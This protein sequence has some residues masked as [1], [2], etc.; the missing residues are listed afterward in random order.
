MLSNKNS[1]SRAWRIAVGKP[2]VI[3]V[4]LGKIF[5]EGQEDAAEAAIIEIFYKKEK[6][7]DCE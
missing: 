4:A 6:I 2:R 1:L 5:R 3:V 7:D